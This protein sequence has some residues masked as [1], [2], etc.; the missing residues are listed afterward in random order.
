MIDPP[1]KVGVIGCG[2]QGKNHLRVIKELGA[3]T[4]V[5]SAFCDLNPERLQNAKEEWPQAQ[6]TDN[7]KFIAENGLFPRD[8]CARR[9]RLSNRC[10]NAEHPSADGTC[11]TRS[12]GGCAL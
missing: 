4:A 9:T 12:G 8:A 11:G 6:A 2:A 3:E 10:H 7:V 5:V 1:V